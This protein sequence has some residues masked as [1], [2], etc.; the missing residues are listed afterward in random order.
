MRF[1]KNL[2]EKDLKK[3][4]LEPENKIETPEEYNQIQWKK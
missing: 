4:I 2:E 1:K 3:K